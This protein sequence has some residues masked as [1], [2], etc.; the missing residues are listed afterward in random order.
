MKYSHTKHY[1]Y[2]LEEIEVTELKILNVDFK[3]PYMEL[4]T[5]GM[6]T[7]N[8]GY[9]WNGSSVPF[10]KTIFVLSLSLWDCDKYCKIASLVHDAL[11]QAMREGLLSKD[12]KYQADLLYKEMCIKG[13]MREWFADKRFWALRKFGD[14][15]IEPEKHPRNKIYEFL[16]PQQKP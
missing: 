14:P 11:C 15:F 7:I 13:G 9:A 8:R 16:E 12:H 3:T 6:L 2:K 4:W 1:K 5:N 10:K